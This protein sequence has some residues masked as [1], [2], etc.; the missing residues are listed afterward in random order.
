MILGFAKIQTDEQLALVKLENR[1]GRPV[2][3]VRFC[4]LAWLVQTV[5]GQSHSS[6]GRPF[7]VDIHV[8]EPAIHDEMGIVPLSA[9]RELRRPVPW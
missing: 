2:L 3:V 5:N 6:V 1:H 9:I 7:M 4:D 8:R